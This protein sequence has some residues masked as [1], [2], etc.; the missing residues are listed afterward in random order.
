MAERYYGIYRGT[1]M[2]TTD[3][4][5]KSR[6][7]VMVPSISGQG[8]GWASAC[9]TPGATALPKVGDYAYVMFEAGVG[10]CFVFCQTSPSS[11]HHTVPPPAAITLV[12]SPAVS[13]AASLVAP[14]AFG[15]VFDAFHVVPP[16]VEYDVEP[17]L[18]AATR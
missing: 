13:R 9:L 3:P 16:S 11:V 17:S 2:N 12:P 6:I 18:V 14:A 1:V 8:S 7:Q 15:L 10:C 4:Q 5:C